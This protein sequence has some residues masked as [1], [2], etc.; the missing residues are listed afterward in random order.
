MVNQLEEVN[1]KSAKTLTF[2]AYILF[3]IGI[4]SLGV[5]SIIGVILA[6]VRRENLQNTIYYGHLSYLI[7]TFWVFIILV[8]I[9]LILV[10]AKGIGVIILILNYIWYIYRLVSGFTKLSDNKPIN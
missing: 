2:I 1:E 8:I 3:F 9:G 7:K 10:N 5:F 4:V 6:Y